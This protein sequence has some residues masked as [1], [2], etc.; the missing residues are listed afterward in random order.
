MKN[1]HRHR[2]ALISV[3]HK[4]GLEELANTLIELGISIISTGGT[5][6]FLSEK[7]IP[8]TP[9]EELT[10]FPEIFDG[11]VKTLHPRIFGGLLQRGDADVLEA[12]KHNIGA[13]DLLIVNLYPF[14]QTLRSGADFNACIEQIDIGGVSLLRAAA[15]NH[16]HVAVLSS[17]AQY[18]Q[19]LESIRNSEAQTTYIFR[20]QLAAQAFMQTFAYDAAIGSWLMDDA[21]DAPSALRYGEN[22]HQ[23]GHFFGNLSDIFTQHAGKALSYNNL[24]DLDAAVRCSMDLQENGIAIFKHTNPCGMALHQNGTDAFNRALAGDPVSAFGGLILSRHP[25]SMEMAQ[26]MNSLFFEM[27]LAPSYEPGVLELL[28]QKKNRILLEGPLQKTTKR[29]FRSVLGGILLQD[30][31]LNEITCDTWNWVTG[32]PPGEPQLRDLHLAIV[33][34][35]HLKSNAIS[36]VKEGQLIGIGCGHVSRIDAMRHAI[37]KAR[38]FGHSLQGAVLASD[39]FFPFPD[40]IALAAEA[41]VSAIVQPGGSVR[42]EQVIQAARDQNLPMALCGMRLFKH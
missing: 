2:N 3:Y 7:N 5:G 22:P 15:K 35:R 18:P 41:G 8:Y 23:T 19:F 28:S 26:A 17:P 6:K 4:D 20:K 33:A 40:S 29:E 27:L 30:S 36:L 25:V 13:I 42:D 16:E 31:D 14:G 37:A 38:E 39:A 34:V 32:K 10:N 24:L 9:V 12:E 1:L 21:S 11:R